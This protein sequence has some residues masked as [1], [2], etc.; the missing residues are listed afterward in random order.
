MLG[1]NVMGWWPTGGWLFAI[2]DPC[3]LS[4]CIESICCE[5]RWRSQL[6]WR[7]FFTSAVVAV[8]VRTAMRWCGNGNC[9]HFGSGGFIIWD[10]SGW[11]ILIK[12]QLSSQGG[13]GAPDSGLRGKVECCLDVFK[14]I[15][16]APQA[17]SCWWLPLLGIA[18]VKMTIHFMSF[19]LWQCLVLLEDY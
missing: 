18:G 3:G 15:S 9:G 10:I 5:W 2:L 4:F 16:S 11:V 6:L 7:V 13:K 12:L 14:V 19:C 1:F 17:I 8:V